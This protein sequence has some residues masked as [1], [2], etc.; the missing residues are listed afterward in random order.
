LPNLHT[1][2]AWTIDSTTKPTALNDSF[3]RSLL[4]NGAVVMVNL[5]RL[6]AGALDAIESG[7]YF[8]IRYSEAAKPLIEACSGRVL[9]RRAASRKVRSRCPPTP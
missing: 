1:K 8:H 7:W 6:R 5:V 4:D 9:T 3:I 2:P